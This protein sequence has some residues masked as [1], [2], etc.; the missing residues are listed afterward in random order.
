MTSF[1]FHRPEILSLS[2]GNGAQCQ[3]SS[4]TCALWTLYF[5]LQEDLLQ[6]WEAS[7][8]K[9]NLTKL[10]KD[11]WNSITDKMGTDDDSVGLGRFEAQDALG[12]DFTTCVWGL[13]LYQPNLLQWPLRVQV[14]GGL[15]K[16]QL[17][18]VQKLWSVLPACTATPAPS[19]ASPAQRR[20]L[21]QPA[22]DCES[23]QGEMH[24]ASAPLSW[25]RARFYFGV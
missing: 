18:G 5:Y 11:F 19:A 22:E 17:W 7:S 8:K 14:W 4:P 10:G 1:W 12:K 3:I 25:H 21:M 2:L 15:C 20:D 23:V 13:S 16:G 6:T 24:S 9:G